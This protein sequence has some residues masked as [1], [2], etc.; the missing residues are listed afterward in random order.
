MIDNQKSN[1]IQDAKEQE[2]SSLS[3]LDQ[4]VPVVDSRTWLII[5]SVAVLI[6]G[7]ILWSF[8]GRLPLYVSGH[9][10]LIKPRQIT[11]VQAPSQGRLVSL[12]VQSGEKV[13]KGQIISVIDQSEL[14]QELDQSLSDLRSLLKQN[15]ETSLLDQERIAY[16]RQSLIDQKYILQ[17]DLLRAENLLPSDEQGTTDYLDTSYRVFEEELIQLQN[18]SAQLNQKLNAYEKLFQQGAI[19]NND[20]LQVKQELLNNQSK[21]FQLQ[22]QIKQLKVQDNQTKRNRIE[23]L[24]LI[25]DLKNRLIQIDARLAELNQK[26]LETSLGRQNKVAELKRRISQLQL[27]LA[28]RGNV[29]S[30]YDGQILEISGVTG[31]LIEVGSKLVTIE[32]EDEKSSLMSIAYFPD[33]YGKQIKEGMTTQ[34]TPSIVKR[35]QYGGILG[36]VKSISPFPVGVQDVKSVVGSEDLAKNFAEFFAKSGD[37]ALI[38]VYVSLNP[39]L[40]TP[41]RYEWSSSLGPTVALTSGT[42]TSVRVKIGERAPITYLLPTLRSLTGLYE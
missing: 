33:K 39:S 22:V 31:Q 19:N 41:S 40:S 29:I 20:M 25:S 30:P 15:E 13:K 23:S 24:S 4:I 42:T 18:L 10:I 28:N 3:G 26:T 27:Q 6:I 35:E 1:L 9:G 16:E 21:I 8:F 12:R 14:Q 32:I 2:V 36:S 38:Q 7:T 5:G 17:K 37:I 11:G 34:V